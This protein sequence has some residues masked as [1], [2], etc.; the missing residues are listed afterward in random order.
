MGRGL[1]RRG[2]RLPVKPCHQAQG[3]GQAPE[4]LPAR[5]PPAAPPACMRLRAWGLCPGR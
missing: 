4:L 1:G 2:Q 5:L 3:E